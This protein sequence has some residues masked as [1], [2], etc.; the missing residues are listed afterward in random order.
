M[1]R[2]A[3]NHGLKKGEGIGLTRAEDAFSEK[4]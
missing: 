3:G 1:C 4:W 2:Q